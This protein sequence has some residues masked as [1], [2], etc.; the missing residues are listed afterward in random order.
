MFDT[1][2]KELMDFLQNLKSNGVSLPYVEIF[3]DGSANVMSDD[4]ILA[5]CLD[6]RRTQ[7]ETVVEKKV[8]VKTRIVEY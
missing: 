7:F 2:I 6:I 8:T 3:S 5:S 1:K 4:K